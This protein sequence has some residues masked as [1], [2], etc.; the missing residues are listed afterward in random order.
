MNSESLH[1]TPHLKSTEQNIT[2]NLLFFLV[3]P[4]TSELSEFQQ[5][6]MARE[7]WFL[8]IGKHFPVREI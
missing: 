6:G 7:E 8:S 5:G 4:L 2:C 1:V 3:F